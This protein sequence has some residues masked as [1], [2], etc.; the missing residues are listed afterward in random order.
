MPRSSAPTL[1]PAS[2]ESKSFLNISTPVT[3][4]LR[5]GRM[6]DDLDLVAHVDHA[7]LDA[8]RDHRA[9]SLDAEDVLDRHQERL[10]LRALRL[11]DVVVHR[12]HQLPDRRVLRRLRVLRGGLQ[13][14][15]RRATHDRDVVPRELVVREQLAQLQLDQLQELLVLH[16][17]DLVEEDDDR[18]HLHLPRQQQVLPRLR[19]RPV[20]RR[21]DEDRPVHLRRARDHVLNVVRVTRAVD[22]RVVPRLRLVLDVLDRDR[23]P[24]RTLFRRVVDGVD[25]RYTASP[26][27]ASTFVIAA[28]RVVFPWSTCPIVPTFAC[29]F[30]RSNLAFAIPALPVR[31]LLASPAWTPT[32]EVMEPSSRFELLTSFLP[33][34]RS[35][36]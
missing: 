7:A 8:P 12:L 36:D 22:V 27:S 20:R 11:R 17:V 23:D 34:T 21:H 14:L 29:G 9:A 1:S 2:P 32:V 28:V 30:V 19:H 4:V 35:T 25:G 31:F 3:V 5:V 10:V 15:K 13:R 16:H 26:F 33:R 18:W 24:A 6:P